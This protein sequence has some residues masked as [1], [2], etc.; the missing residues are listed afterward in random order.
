MSEKQRI[1][2]FGAGGH[3]KVII[4]ALGECGVEVDTIFDD[5]LSKTEL[6]G[7][8]IRQH[9][10]K[11]PLILAIGNNAV[12]KNIANDFSIEMFFPN[13][14]SKTA[15]VSKSAKIGEGSVVLQGAIIQASTIIG[16]HVIIN[17]GASVDHDCVIENF[18]H[19]APGCHLCGGVHV[20]EGTIIGVGSVVIPGVKIG[21]WSVIGAG[22]VVVRDIPDN[23]TCV[24]NPCKEIIK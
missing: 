13:A 4:E 21:K 5:D 12:R 8:P 10:V 24:G 7:I 11:S 19:I 9:D 3:A 18:A 1:N 22:S 23:I 2:I 6:L 14:I 15:I 17:T 20:G 16:N